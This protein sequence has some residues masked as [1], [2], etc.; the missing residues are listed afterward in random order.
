VDFKSA[1]ELLAEGM[2]DPDVLAVAAEDG[3]IVVSHDVSTMPGHFRRFLSDGRSSP[4]L[5]LIPQTV[6]VSAGIEQLVLIWAAS[7]A[8]EWQDQLVWLPL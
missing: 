2:Q 3:R 1:Q 4:G 5:F 7:E 8:E 6:S